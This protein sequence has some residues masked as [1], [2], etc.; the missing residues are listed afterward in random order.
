MREPHALRHGF[1]KKYNRLPPHPKMTNRNSQV[2]VLRSI[3]INSLVALYIIVSFIILFYKGHDHEVQLPMVVKHEHQ[4]MQTKVAAE[5][6]EQMRG[7][8]TIRTVGLR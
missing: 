8:D 5:H 1:L 4:E 7:K 6:H 2:G 3:I